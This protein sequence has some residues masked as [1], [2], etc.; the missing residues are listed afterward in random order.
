M[1]RERE[2]ALSDYLFHCFSGT[3]EVYD[4]IAMLGG[5]EPA[6]WYVLRPLQ[7]FKTLE[8]GNRILSYGVYYWPPAYHYTLI[9]CP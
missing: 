6:C 5:M 4:T 9:A 7:L 1:E 3:C 8:H 2:R